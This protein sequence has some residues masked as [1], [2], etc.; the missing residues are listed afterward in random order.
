MNRK[1]CSFSDD[2][3]ENFIEENRAKLSRKITWIHFA[4]ALSTPLA[5]SAHPLMTFH[6]K[7]YNL[8]TYRSI[9]F[10]TEKGKRNFKELFPELPNQSLE[11]DSSKKNL[12]HAWCSMAGNFTS[13][14]WSEFFKKL[15]SEF[16][17]KKEAAFPYLMKITG[18]I[19]ENPK[20]VTGPIERGDKETINR[21]LHALEEDDF[22]KVYESFLA[23]KTKESELK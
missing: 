20:A 22:L 19:I 4:G 12:Y 23:V 14:L 10:V 7:L 1:Y 11:I 13:I 6:D 9:S 5:E 2:Q 21:H 15:E 16:N 18:N 3:I 8:E 17:I